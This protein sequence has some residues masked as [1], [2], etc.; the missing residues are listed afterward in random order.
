MMCVTHPVAGYFQGLHINF[1]EF[2][3]IINIKEVILTDFM[4][5]VTHPMAGYFQGL[6][7][8]FHTNLLSLSISRK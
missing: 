7:I 1:H 2:A 4:Y 8:N 6:H 5:V 3:L